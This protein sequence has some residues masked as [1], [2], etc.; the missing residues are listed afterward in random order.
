MVKQTPTRW[1]I[2][3]ELFEFVWSF[4]GVGASKVNPDM[5]FV[6]NSQAYFENVYFH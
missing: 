5:Y 6:K 4:C 3:D 2:A 1:Q